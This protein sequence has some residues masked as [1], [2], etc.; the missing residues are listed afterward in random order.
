MGVSSYTKPRESSIFSGLKI[1]TSQQ[2][3]TLERIETHSFGTA[4]IYTPK[5]GEMNQLKKYR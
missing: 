1:S 3:L 4:F 5:T 2:A